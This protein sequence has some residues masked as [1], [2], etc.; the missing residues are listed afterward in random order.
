[1]GDIQ[2]NLLGLKEAPSVTIELV[3]YG[4]FVEKSAEHLSQ[5]L[6]PSLANGDLQ[7]SP[8]YYVR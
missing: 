6:S 1:M 3:L 2:T 7:K 8:G 5:S 4:A